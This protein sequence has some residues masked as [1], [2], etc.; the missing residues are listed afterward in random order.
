MKIKIIQVG[1]S[2]ELDFENVSRELTKRISGFADIEVVTIAETKLSATF[3]IQKVL[4]KEGKDILKIVGNSSQ[5]IVLDERGKEF[6]SKQFS[7]FIQ[8][9][10]DSGVSLC[11]VIGGAF[12]LSQEVKE[13]ATLMISMSKMTFTHQM[14]RVFLLEQIY[15][16][17]C[18]MRGKEYHHE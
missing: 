14:I 18:I 2:K 3:T 4:E 8:K 12:G 17:F 6:D 16:A 7:N 13:R 5:V 11:F 9:G 1:K 15:R 10:E